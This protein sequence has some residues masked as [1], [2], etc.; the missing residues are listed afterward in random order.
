MDTVLLTGAAGLLGR[1]LLGP[2]SKRWNV[3]AVDARPLAPDEAAAG[4]AASLSFDLR[5]YGAV[6]D[7]FARHRIDFVVHAGAISHPGP[8]FSHPVSS[9]QVNFDATVTLLE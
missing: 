5:D 4:P 2:L 1:Q 6:Y 8:S 7:A 3:I 9:V